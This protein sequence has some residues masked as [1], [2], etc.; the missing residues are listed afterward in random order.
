MDTETYAETMRLTLR[1]YD[2][3]RPRSKQ[4][5]AYLLGVSDI[6]G[7]PQYAKLLTEQT[8]FSDAPDTTA[9]MWGTFLHEGITKARAHANPTLIHDALVKI[10]LPNGVEVQGHPDEIDPEENSITDYKTVD[11]IAVPRRSGPTEK[12]EFQVD[13][14]A[15]GA[16]QA[17]LLDPDKPI[18]VRIIWFDRAGKDK[19]PHVW[20]KEWHPDNVN[21]AVDWLDSVMYAVTN[22]EDAERTPP[23]DF[24][25]ATCPFYSVCRIPDLPEVD[26]L[27]TDETIKQA[28]DSYLAGQVMSK[29][30]E[31][32]KRSAKSLIDGVSGMVELDD[33]RQVRARWISIGASKVAATERHPYK[34]LSLLEVK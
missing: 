26:E 28:V 15:L 8:P 4:T 10:N 14:Y 31:A 20:Q 18:T 22:H 7:C 17:G 1:S 27:I 11:G 12:Q 24:C 21:P 33:G 19:I 6:G 3:Q 34:R 25:A 23:V 29:E 2:S 9:A 30:G 5:Q 13:L 16:V 32:L